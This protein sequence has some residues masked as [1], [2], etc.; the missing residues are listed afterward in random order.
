MLAENM[1]HFPR[2]AVWVDSQKNKKKLLLD[3]Y[4][5]PLFFKSKK[6]SRAYYVCSKKKAHNCPVSV[7]LDVKTD[8]IVR[9]TGN[10]THDSEIVSDIT[11][12]V[13]SNSNTADGLSCTP[14]YKT[15]A[16]NI[17]RKRKFELDCPPIPRSGL[18]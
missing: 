8:M 5:V 15:L 4:S 10:H 16:E 7:S 9:V 17:Q 6:T 3:P 11:S 1:L 14:K 18:R 12:E 13:L 2:K